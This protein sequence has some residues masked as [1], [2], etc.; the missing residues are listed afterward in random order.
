MFFLQQE[1]NNQRK[2]SKETNPIQ[3]IWQKLSFP[4]PYNENPNQEHKN[5]SKHNL[6]IKIKE[7][8]LE[9]P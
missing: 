4:N 3:K 7:K 6:K 8:I 5:F 2:S 1:A 9:L